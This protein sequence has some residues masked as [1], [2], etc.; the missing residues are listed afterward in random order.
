MRALYELGLAQALAGTAAGEF[1]AA[2]YVRSCID[3]T[4]QVEPLIGAFAHFDA[5]A[6]E[7]RLADTPEP[8]LLTG[9]PVALK[10][11]MD[12]RGVPTEYGSAAFAGHVPTKSAWVAVAL[13]RAGALLFGKTVT[14]EFAW[15]HPGR[16]RN[17][18]QREHTPGGSSSG[19]AAA[20][21]CGCVPAAVG[22]QTLGSVIRPAAYCGVVGYKPSFGMTPRTGTFPLAASLDHIGVFARSVTDAA[23][24]AAVLTGRDG[25]DF[26]D[27]PAPV[28]AWPLEMT[29]SPP[30]LGWLRGPLW[31]RLSDEQKAT[32]EASAQRL[33]AAGASITSV[34]WPAPFESMWEVAR[35][36]VEAEGAAVHLAQA[37]TQPPR[38]SEPTVALYERGR[39]I[40]AIDYI[41]AREV[42][43]DLIR[44]FAVFMSPF[45]ALLSAPALGAAPAGLGD[46]GD[47]VCATPFTLLGAPALTL[48][49][50]TLSREGLPMGLQ[51]SANRGQD[52]TLLETALWVER[53]L[54]RGLFFPQL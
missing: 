42:Q 39:M 15:R 6:L 43:Q 27:T 29:S 24:V 30:R 49:A 16:T 51:L 44:R 53:T 31:Q 35:I 9:M 8:G 19:S 20:V 5:A 48:P 36:L 25:I 23:L 40:A 17:P 38:V 1:S 14:T 46:T 7:A 12:A 33:E 32:L 3:R 2:D 21:A 10:D 26:P 52:R 28:R 47:A 18:W 22:T 50:G 34:D 4:R 13:E 37:T 11:I 41:R 45:D 54:D